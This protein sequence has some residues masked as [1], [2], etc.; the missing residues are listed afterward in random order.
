MKKSALLICALLGLVWG[1]NFIFVKW[2]THTVSPVQITLLRVVFGFI[3]VML[4][5]LANG[6]LRWSH[7]RHAH[8]FLVMSMLATAVYY[9]AF[10]EGTA[11]L[12]FG[13]AGMLGG[14]IPLFTFL[15]AWLFL[16][17]EPLTSLKVAGIAMGFLGVLLIA[18]P[19]SAAGEISQAGVGY[20][21]FGS[22]SV[23]C[24]FV[25]ARRFISPLGLPAVALTTYQ[26]GFIG[27]LW[28]V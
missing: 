17:S 2:A 3:P 6:A 12:P 19:W 4:Y 26:I 1:S 14:A 28:G 20:M 11:L 9:Y 21:M 22:L 15:C 8:H 10:A 18:Q 25:Y 16:R 5:A 27:A 23:G 24:S 13:I 7:W